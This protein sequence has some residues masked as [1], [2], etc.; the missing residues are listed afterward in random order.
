MEKRHP[1]TV[2]EAVDHLSSLAEIDASTSSTDHVR[3]KRDELIATFHVIHSYLQ[4]LYEKEKGQL[5][6]PEMQRAVQ[7]IMILTSEAVQKMD[8]Y[9]GKIAESQE[10]QQ[11]QAFYLNKVAKRFRQPVEIQQPW[12]EETE[13]FLDTAHITSEKQGLKDLEAVRKDQDYELFYI[14]KENGQPFFNS[15]LLRHVRLVGDFEEVV[16]EPGSDDPLLKVEQ[17]K[18]RD[19]HA[20]ATEI[21]HLATPYLDD[22]YKQALRHKERDLVSALNKAIMALM[23]CANPRNHLP[24]AAGKSCIGY[25]QDFH[26]FLREALHSDGYHRYLSMSTTPTDPLARVLL[27]LLHLLCFAF[28]MRK[29]NRKEVVHFIRTLILQTEKHRDESWTELLKDDQEMRTLLKKFPNGPLLKTFDFFREEERRKGFDPLGQGNFPS[30]LYT[31]TLQDLHVTTLRLP[32]PTYQEMIDKAEVIPEFQNFLRALQARKQTYLLFDLQDRTS[33]QEH[34]RSVALENLQKRAEFARNLTVITLS[35]NTDFYHQT[36]PYQ[37][38]EETGLFLS[39]LKDQIESGES[40]GFFFSSAVNKAA[41]LTFTD[42]ALQMIH[43]HV[44]S[45]KKRLSQQER[46][47]FIEIFYQFLILKMILLV[48]PDSLSFTCKDAID[49]GE[50]AAASFFSFLKMLIGPQKW[51]QDEL[52]LL[53]WMLYAPALFMRHRLIDPTRLGRMVSALSALQTAS[54]TKLLE[55]TQKLFDADFSDFRYSALDHP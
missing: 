49:T 27:N 9:G 50:A 13:A 29:N 25:F 39:S 24:S 8:Q 37:L 14:V 52:D 44:F 33:W 45:S 10:Y 30:Q 3:A 40:C 15:A 16:S 4:N 17:L 54:Q 20:A 6:D 34:A 42:E 48:K 43:Q 47:D 51:S 32:S 21:L 36:G 1:I 23:L 46:L 22:F 11:L 18:D 12:E 53:Q 2:I 28:F 41:I 5:K 38:M 19:L 35:K 55:Q 7:A 26:S 31:F